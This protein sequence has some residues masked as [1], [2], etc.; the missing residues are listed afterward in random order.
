M[1]I[2]IDLDDKDYKV[3]TFN[4]EGDVGG[5]FYFNSYGI[6]IDDVVIN[7]TRNTAIN[8]ITELKKHLD[9]GGGNI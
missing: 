7:I 2:N 1:D 3:S 8:L 4:G 5:G 6:R 9:S